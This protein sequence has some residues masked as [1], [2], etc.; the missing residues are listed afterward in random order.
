M[1]QR[2]LYSGQTVVRLQMELTA[3]GEDRRTSFRVP[4]RYGL[5]G[6]YSAGISTAALPPAPRDVLPRCRARRGRPRRI[7]VGIRPNRPSSSLPS[8]LPNF[9]TASSAAAEAAAAGGPPDNHRTSSGDSIPDADLASN[10]LARSLTS[11][12]YRNVPCLDW[13][14][15]GVA[16]EQ[17][18]NL[19]CRLCLAGRSWST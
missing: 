11:V 1:G 13:S 8:E 4:E 10:P 5:L 17:E 12:V 19:G 15:A 2:L 18:E 7:F 16:R 14:I 6:S 3:R 9:R